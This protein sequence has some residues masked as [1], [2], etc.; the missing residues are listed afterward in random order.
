[1]SQ[2]SHEQHKTLL[3]LQPSVSPC[4]HLHS[5]PPPLSVFISHTEPVYIVKMP[6]ADKRPQAHAGV[7][8]SPPHSPSPLLLPSLPPPPLCAPLCSLLAC[9]VDTSWHVAKSPDHLSALLSCPLFSAALTTLLCG[10]GRGRGGFV[11]S[12]SLLQV[13]YSERQEPASQPDRV[14]SLALRTL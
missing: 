3:Y 14:A 11:A 6:T 12:L 1:M 9:V 4:T 5:P 10:K 7:G 2:S 13:P 8:Y